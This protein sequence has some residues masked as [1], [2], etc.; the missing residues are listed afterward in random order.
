MTIKCSL[1]KRFLAAFT[2]LLIVI[3]LG[4]GINLLIV[5]PIADANFN[6]TADHEELSYQQVH[7]FLYVVVDKELNIVADGDSS[8]EE[9]LSLDAQKNTL[10][11]IMALTNYSDDDKYDGMFFYTYLSR[12]FS[13]LSSQELVNEYYKD[14]SIFN[15]L[16]GKYVLKDDVSDQ[17][18]LEFCNKVYDDIPKFYVYY[19][20]G[21]L[22]SLMYSVMV[23]DFLCIFISFIIPALLNYIVLP[24][25]LSSRGT[26]GKVIFRLAVVN[27]N[28]IRANR[29]VM[30]GRGLFLLIVELALSIVAMG[31]P[32]IVSFVISLFNNE[33][34]SLHDLACFT[35]V[36]DLKEFTPFKDKEE[37]DKYVEEEGDYRDKS[38]RRPYEN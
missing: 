21:I 34:K 15:Y 26:I 25:C 10:A 3:L 5:T 20:N 13:E 8:R 6:L 28:Y 19:Q 29:L 37:F 33:G 11:S 9:I 24:L 36:L 18:L 31:I 38:L 30:V 27:N 17:E 2:D 7:S 4:L 22:S 12:F 35:L 23:K 14:S 1:W 16:D 32:L